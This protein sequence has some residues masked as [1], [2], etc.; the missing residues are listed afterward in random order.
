VT[1]FLWQP[2]CKIPEKE[3]MKGVSQGNKGKVLLSGLPTPPSVRGGR[4]GRECSQIGKKNCLPGDS[5]FPKR[6]KK[7]K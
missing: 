3:Q 2:E 4:G 1:N 6:K 5:I 7:K